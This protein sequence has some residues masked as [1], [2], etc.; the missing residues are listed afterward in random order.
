MSVGIVARAFCIV[1]F[2]IFND[3]NPHDK[4]L[5]AAKGHIV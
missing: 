1:H 2:Q 3:E 5:V 4:R